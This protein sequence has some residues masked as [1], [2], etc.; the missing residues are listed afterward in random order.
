MK[1]GPKLYIHTSLLVINIRRTRKALLNK[2]YF[3]TYY[4]FSIKKSTEAKLLS[5]LAKF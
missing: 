2:T 4:I 5:K 3:P 1:L